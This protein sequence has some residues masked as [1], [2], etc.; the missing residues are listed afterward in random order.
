MSPSRRGRGR[1]APWERVVE[2]ALIAACFSVAVPAAYFGLPEW[3]P[4]FACGALL[5]IADTYW[6]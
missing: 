5:L 1:R 6:P 4:V 2:R 3:A